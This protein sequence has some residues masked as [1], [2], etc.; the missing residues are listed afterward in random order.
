M[1]LSSKS[2]LQLSI[3]KF[4]FLILFISSIGMLA[5][6]SN[7]Y[8]YQF[9]LTA[10]KRH[11]LSDNSIGLL[12]L[13]DKPVTVHAYSTDEV[14]QTA[15]KEIIAR[16][17][18]I[19]SDFDVKLLNPDI[20]IEQ[21]QRDGIVMNK[22]FAFVIYYNQRMEHIDSLSEQAISNALL[23][24]NRRDNQQVVFLKGHGERDIDGTDNRA[25]SEL[26]QQLTDMGFNL[27]SINLLETSLPDNTKLL[28]IAAP[29]HPYLDGELTRIDDYLKKG[30]NLLWL[31]D[32][33]ELQGLKKLA[34]SLGLQLQDG[35][36]IDN[37]PELRQTL[38]IQ[39]PAFI[40][41]TEYFPHDI[42]NTLRYNTL[43]PMARGISPL[44]NENLV[45]NWLAHAL[46]NSAGKS[47]SEMGGLKE[48]MAFESS[49]GDIA[50]PITIAVAL[51]R[52]SSAQQNNTT[53]K[54]NSGVHTQRAVL[55]RDSDFLSDTYICASAN[56]YLG[57]NIFNWLIGD[58]DFIS[59]ETGPSPDT[60]LTLN[61]TQLMII[62]FGFFL[63]IPVVLLS[64]GFR[65]WYLR[66]NR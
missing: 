46:F 65:I 2:R 53:G 63:V 11:S 66:K 41:V 19:K 24:L 54:S 35:I 7:H 31:A 44:T 10:N 27:K 45:N 28:V 26:R 13:L 18:R 21:A 17:Q 59:V 49:A 16:Y 64:I 40:P 3:Q 4:I 20:D 37:N 51:Q 36:I 43:F 1:K 61:D 8:T 57:L 15:I 38:N 30:G 52:E 6:I 14:T 9:D 60:K 5:W 34:T 22:P 58:D 32:P 56:L 42:T 29:S 33:G 47:W 48:E 12:E 55:I 23:R 50:G 39:H 62:A 25:Y